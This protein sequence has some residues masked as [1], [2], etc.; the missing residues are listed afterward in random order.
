VQV[1]ST[2]LQFALAASGPTPTG[3]QLTVEGASGT[4]AVIIEG[5]SDLVHWQPLVTNAP[6]QGTL[7]FLDT[8]ALGLP[9]RFYLAVQAP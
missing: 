2:H 6:I 3:F 7:Q 4:N 9:R 8:S 5:S 1:T